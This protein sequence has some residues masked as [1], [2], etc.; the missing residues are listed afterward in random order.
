[1]SDHIIRVWV[2]LPEQLCFV[3]LCAANLTLKWLIDPNFSSGQNSKPSDRKLI[4]I[5]DFMAIHGSF[6]KRKQQIV[7]NYSLFSLLY[8]KCGQTQQN[9][10]RFFSRNN[11]AQY[12]LYIFFFRFLFF[13]RST[14]HSM[15]LSASRSVLLFDSHSMCF[16]F[17]LC[18]Y[19]FFLLLV[20]VRLW[21]RLNS[22]QFG[23]THGRQ[24]PE[25]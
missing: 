10:P 24:Y 23:A 1:M 18:L 5:G 7:Q 2:F 3:G 22:F 15:R 19:L 12:F 8:S 6:V 9:I 20:V 14:F 21:L 16:F 11:N 4:K 17:W 13:I 25:Y